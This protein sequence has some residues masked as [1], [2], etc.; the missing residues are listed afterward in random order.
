MGSPEDLGDETT[1]TEKES[2]TS[3][4]RKENKSKKKFYRNI[5]DKKLGGVCSGI[6]AYFGWDPLPVRLIFFAL[7]FLTTAWIIPFYLILWILMPAALS[8]SQKL[9]M[10]GEAVT[11]ENIGKT[12]SETVASVK[13][14]E[15]ESFLS[16]VF[17]IFGIIFSCIVGFPLLIVFFVLIV[18]LI[19]MTFGVGSLFFIPLDFLGL[20]CISM[21][22]SYPVI[23][24]VSLI[25]IIGIPLFSIIYSVF[26]R[27]RKTSSFPKQTKLIVFLIWIID[28]KSVV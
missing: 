18:V 22:G 8:A 21:N 9:E 24:I 10:K 19:A 6:A 11:L 3:D 2:V 23:G 1:G 28:R 4:D 7:I 20:D 17:K 15:I 5:D 25:I 13:T 27:S 16:A 14:N 12:V 26:F